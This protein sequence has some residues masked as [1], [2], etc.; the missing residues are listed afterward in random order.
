MLCYCFCVAALCRPSA[1]PG[2]F[3]CQP[4]NSSAA[5]VSLAILPVCCPSIVPS[6]LP[7]AILCSLWA[8]CWHRA[9]PGRT[10]RC[11]WS[12]T[13]SV[14]WRCRHLLHVSAVYWLFTCSLQV[15]L[16]CL[17]VKNA[18]L[19]KV[20]LAISH[21]CQRLVGWLRCDRLSW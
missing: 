3:A 1:C 2:L 13:E 16:T 4:Q 19:N 10:G 21:S 5:C 17:A 11:Y 9:V 15:L 14:G 18:V 8:V 20:S 6:R 7:D 12:H